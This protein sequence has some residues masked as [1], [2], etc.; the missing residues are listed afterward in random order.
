[1]TTTFNTRLSGPEGRRLFLYVLVQGVPFVFQEHAT[2]VPASVQSDV[3]SRTVTKTIEKVEVSEKRIDLAPG[4]LRMIG[5]SLTVTLHETATRQLAALFAPR[6]RR[7]TFM[8]ADV[9]AAASTMFVDDTSVLDEGD[10]IYVDGESIRVDAVNSATEIDVNRAQWSSEAQQHF[11]DT[12]NGAG[13][14]LVPP[15]W[16]GRRVTL[17]GYLVDQNGQTSAALSTTLDTFRLEEAP[18]YVGDGTWELRCSHLSDEFA[19]RKIG[20]GL[21][22]VDAAAGEAGRVHGGQSINFFD[23][24]DIRQFVLG[25]TTTF[26]RY[27]VESGKVGIRPITSIVDTLSPDGTINMP[28]GPNLVTPQGL[29]GTL[30]VDSARHIAILQGEPP[31]ASIMRA[32]TSRVGDGAN[33][34]YDTLP[35]RA[36]TIFSEDEWRFGAGILAAEVDAAAWTDVCGSPLPGWSLVIDDE[37]AVDKFLADVCFSTGSFWFVNRSGQLSVKRL[38][39]ARQSVVMAIDEDTLCTVV[40]DGGMEPTI[41]YA[42]DSI[43]PRIM[44]RCNYD[45]ASRAFEGTLT[46]IDAELAARYPTDD[47]RCE[48]ESRSLVIR[49]GARPIPTGGPEGTFLRPSCARQQ[50]DGI[51]RRVQVAGGRGRALIQ[52]RCL[53]NALQLELGDVVTFSYPLPDYEGAASI[54]ARKCRVLA[55]AP[56]FESS[57]VDLTLEVLETL[58]HIAPAAVIAS[59]DGTGTILTLR[60][61]GPEVSSSTPG[62]MFGASW[63]LRIYDVSAGT[64][65]DRIVSGTPTD[66]TITL[67][68]ALG[69]AIEANV[70]FVTLDTQADAVSVT[71]DSA[72]G[73]GTEEFTFTMEADLSSAAPVTRWR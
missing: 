33:G 69:F 44:M 57:L 50:V 36:R 4:K 62:R 17:C 56:D 60:T 34:T 64:H 25:D 53:V 48:V 41:T 3:A 29:G 20:S 65:V 9:T 13:V 8:I 71:A 55:I 35:G 19:A 18:A 70:D 5:G 6:A 73:F 21:F 30:V 23:V 42:E 27:E 15:A 72:N 37:I 51:L 14:F 32:L 54:S 2:S 58:F 39:E 52:C 24:V 7:T 10:T 26:V 47:N 49:E 12:E 16:K 68:V 22:D 66:T 61:T 11:G 38:A 1:M 59:V 67:T 46:M 63:K 43:F 45:P 31:G 40:D 28:A